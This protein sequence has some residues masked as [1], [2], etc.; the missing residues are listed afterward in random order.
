MREY[1]RSMQHSSDED[2]IPHWSVFMRGPEDKFLYV[3]HV[4]TD[5]EKQQVRF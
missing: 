2:P 1:D 5:S 3:G 4:A